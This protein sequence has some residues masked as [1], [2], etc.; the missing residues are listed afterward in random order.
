MKRHDERHTSIDTEGKKNNNKVTKSPAGHLQIVKLVRLKADVLLDNSNCCSGDGSQP[1]HFFI[2]PEKLS[3]GRRGNR[4]DATIVVH[5]AAG[6]API[7]LIKHNARPAN[8]PG[9]CNAR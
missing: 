6:L 9:P 5:S 7:S 1:A 2:V 3:R 4:P 8:E